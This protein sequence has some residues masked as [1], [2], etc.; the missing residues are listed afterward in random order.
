MEYTSLTECRSAENRRRPVG[1]DS[2]VKSNMGNKLCKDMVYTFE[3]GHMRY[4]KH[5]GA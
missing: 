3:K 5:D 1:A 2:I 4:G